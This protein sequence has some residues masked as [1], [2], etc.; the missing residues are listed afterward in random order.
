MNRRPGYNN[1][2]KS[3]MFSITMVDVKICY[4]EVLT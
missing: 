1:S 4:I 3:K 2:V